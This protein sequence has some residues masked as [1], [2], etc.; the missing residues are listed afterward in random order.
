M[1]R[2]RLTFAAIR[3]AGL[4]LPGVEEGTAYGTAALKVR[5]K[6]IACVPTHRSAEP[7]SLV[8]CV[9]FEDRDALIASDPDTYY[10][11]EHYESY[12][13]VLVRLDRLQPDAV[14]DLLITASRHVGRAGATRPRARARKR[15]R[16]AGRSA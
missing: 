4:A 11:K 9:G 1:P 7:N 2:Q 12:P 3:R 6:M 14:R 15:P 13:V 10:L 8:V 5:G 16:V